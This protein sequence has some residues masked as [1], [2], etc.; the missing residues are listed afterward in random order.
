MFPPFDALFQITIAVWALFCL[1]N[2]NYTE[3]PAIS[4]NCLFTFVCRVI[5]HC[6]QIC[7]KI[8]NNGLASIFGLSD[9]APA[10]S[11]CLQRFEHSTPS[12]VPDPLYLSTS[13]VVDTFAN[14]TQWRVTRMQGANDPEGTTQWKCCIYHKLIVEINRDA[15]FA[16]IIGRAAVYGAERTISTAT[17]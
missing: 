13:S 12:R 1:A 10:I 14:M 16:W 17:D 3:I 7:I 2:N 4:P 5:P 6:R 8:G 9:M 15:E 11:D